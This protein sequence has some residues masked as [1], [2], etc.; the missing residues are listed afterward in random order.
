M[1]EIIRIGTR[2]SKLAIAQAT[3]V[4]ELITTA[5]PNQNVNII[6]ISTAGD[7]NKTDS[8]AKI[9]GKGVF[10]KEIQEALLAGTIDIAVHSMKDLTSR[11]PDAL[12]LSGFLDPES[13]SDVLVSKHGLTLEKLPEGA[14]I[15]TGSM[16]RRALIRRLRPDI[17]LI[18][19]RGNVDTRLEKLKTD[20]IDAILLSEAGLI[21]LNL[22]HHIH[23]RFNPESFLPA[24]GQGVIALEIRAND[25]FSH[26][27]CQRISDPAQSQISSIEYEVLKGLNFN[28]SIPLGM[29]TVLKENRMHIT[30]GIEI[31]GHIWKQWQVDYPRSTAQSDIQ[32]LIGDVVRVLEPS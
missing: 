15:A 2:G 24:P 10:A 8:L 6:I 3:K 27:I 23:E 20:N 30:L 32:G 17:K 16:R 1:S 12:R 4:R 31:A 19:I 21:R 14:T 7:Q 5:N 29:H 18:D 22:Q 13:T 25:T 9:G 11:P 26:D 28:C